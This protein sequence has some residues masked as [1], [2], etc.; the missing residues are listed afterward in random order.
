MRSKVKQFFSRVAFDFKNMSLEEKIYTLYIFLATSTVTIW[1]AT[2][3]LGIVL[4]S[5]RYVIYLLFVIHIY[6]SLKEHKY[7]KEALIL[8]FILG[9]INTIAL[10]TSRE[11]DVFIY[12][13]FLISVYKMEE[14]RLIKYSC[15]I[16]GMV[17]FVTFS[18]AIVGTI[19]NTLI[20]YDRI[21]YSLGFDY[22][23]YAP[24]LYMFVAMQYV[25]LRDSRISW[26]EITVLT[27]F[28]Y[29]FYSLT[30]TKMSFIVT[31]FVLFVILICKYIKDLK[32]KIEAL[33]IKYQKLIV[34]VPFVCLIIAIVLPL[35]K[36]GD[37]YMFI[38]N[39][40]SSR[41]TLSRQAIF[42]YGF[43]LFGQKIN[44]IGYSLSRGAPETYNYVDSSYLQIA[45][46]QGLIVAILTTG[47][48]S[49]AI[50]K[51]FKNKNYCL[52]GIL[53]MICLLSIEDPFLM[54]IKFNIFPIIAFCG[55]DNYKDIKVLHII[56]EK[57]FK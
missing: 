2:G 25:Y 29:I 55:D 8:F 57:I 38:N 51:S 20:G 22:T 24:A 34:L 31:L 32:T 44:F 26:Q 6:I 17:L 53:L 30:H 27:L 33:L 14:K 48:Y 5:L 16:Q 35:S 4:K 13:V 52:I 42:N 7:S 19:N 54:D 1:G 50:L 15:I 11:N 36:Q 28:S 56:S 41:L 12:T 9:L 39:L 49:I 21:R 18:L 3:N 45:L 40:L 43:T 23:S 10:F 46:E 47:I 37:F